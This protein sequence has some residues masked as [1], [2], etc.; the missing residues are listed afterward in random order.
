[1]DT[2]QEI[3]RLDIGCGLP[4]NTMQ[5]YTGVD[6][7]VDTADIQAPMW[8]LPFED[9]TITAIMCSHALEHIAKDMI[10]PSIREWGRVI[11]PGGE[12]EIHVPDLKW[13]LEQW[14]NIGGTGWELDCIFG[15]QEHEG[16]FHKTGFTKDILAQYVRRAGLKITAQSTMFS[17]N[18]P[19]IVIKCTKE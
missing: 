6:P 12:I 19:T 4:A 3:I 2:E 10:V 13:C 15:N 18:Q 9:D 8:R 14:L 5:G 7:F 16:E 17:H 1:M 11:I